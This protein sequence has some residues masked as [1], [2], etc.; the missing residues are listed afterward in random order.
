MLTPFLF[1]INAKAISQCMKQG[2]N[3]KGDKMDIKACIERVRNYMDTLQNW[4]LIVKEKRLDAIWGHGCGFNDMKVQTTKQYDRMENAIIEAQELEER[5]R[6][7]V[8]QYWEEKEAL[9]QIIEQYARIED[10]TTLYMYA[11]GTALS[12]IPL[13]GKQE[14]PQKCVDAAIKRLQKTIDREEEIARQPK[15]VQ[16]LI[17][18]GKKQCKYCGTGFIKYKKEEKDRFIFICTGCGKKLKAD[19]IGAKKQ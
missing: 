18:G 8:E 9:K 16:A 1:V 7:I 15:T 14:N 3:E 2:I 13:I 12:E 10:I 6:K 4:D 11:I 19:K 5:R 17:R